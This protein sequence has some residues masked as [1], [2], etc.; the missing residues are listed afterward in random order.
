MFSINCIWYFEALPWEACL[1]YIQEAWCVCCHQKQQILLL[2]NF[3]INSLLHRCPVETKQ[4]EIKGSTYFPWSFHFLL[5]LEI[6]WLLISFLHILHKLPS[7]IKG[8]HEFG[9]P[10]LEDT[11]ICLFLE[12]CHSPILLCFFL[13]CSF[14]VFISHIKKNLS[15]HAIDVFKLWLSCSTVFSHSPLKKQLAVVHFCPSLKMD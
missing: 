9:L 3:S 4:V 5:L 1:E 8:Y 12:D 11:C 10:S 13:I 6:H 7:Q 15:V 14:T 2:R